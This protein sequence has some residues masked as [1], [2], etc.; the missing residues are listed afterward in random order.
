[1]TADAAGVPL[2]EVAAK[3]GARRATARP[4]ARPGAPRAPPPRT[5]RGGELRPSSRGRA[6]GK[7]GLGCPAEPSPGTS[8][9]HEANTG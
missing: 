6:G 5:P 9:A 1:M 7:A 3:L 2:A 8:P 4:P